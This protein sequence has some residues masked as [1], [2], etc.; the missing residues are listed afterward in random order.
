MPD[1]ALRDR[2]WLRERM[3][4]PERQIGRKTENT[5][6]HRWRNHKRTF[7]TSAG[8]VVCTAPSRTPVRLGT[9]HSLRQ[10]W[11]SQKAAAQ[12]TS[13]LARSRARKSTDTDT[14]RKRERQLV[15]ARGSK[16]SVEQDQ[17]LQ[18]NAEKGE[19]T[20][21]RAIFVEAWYIGRRRKA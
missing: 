16:R 18:I 5:H 14:E 2:R 10:Y 15:I 9:Y 13:T 6:T 7:S 1:I 21:K 17:E 4:E 19:S 3:M 8:T 12:I 11:L 20:A